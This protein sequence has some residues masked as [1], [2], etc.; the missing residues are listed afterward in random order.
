MSGVSFLE[1]LC[2][3]ARSQGAETLALTDTNGLYGAVRFVEAARQ[4]GLKPILGAELSHGSH[5]AVCLV[6]DTEGY[7]NL[8]R[9]ISARHCDRSFNLVQAVEQHRQ[10]LILLSD[11]LPAL[12]T[13]KESSPENLYVE[14]TPGPLMQEAVLFS[15]AAGLPPVATNKVH[16]ATPEGY[17]LHRLL[18]AIDLNT[19]L[20]RLPED[21]CAA[22]T[23]WLAP[24]SILQRYYAHVPEALANTLRVAEAC[25]SDWDFKETIF[26]AF[27][28]FSDAKAFAVLKK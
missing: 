1:E 13:W 6:K 26:P 23:H 7:A 2:D 11:D 14:L 10:G 27:R 5:R 8:C 22:P 15:R 19:T 24:F 20:S 21:A 3:A 9:L 4:R 28:A 25:R 12:A 17:P 16:F 18:R